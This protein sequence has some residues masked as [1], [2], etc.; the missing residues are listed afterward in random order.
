VIAKN[1]KATAAQQY[2]VI[3]LARLGKKQDAKSELEKFQKGDAPES[4]KLY[5]AAIAAAELGDG[6]DKAFE[7]MEAAMGKQPLTIR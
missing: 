6:A 7:A 3:T 4:A 5:L 2:R 1:P